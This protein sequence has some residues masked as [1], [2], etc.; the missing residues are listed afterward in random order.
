MQGVFEGNDNVLH[1]GLVTLPCSFYNTKV[2]FIPNKS[3]GEIEIIPRDK[4]KAVIAAK[5]TLEYFNLDKIYGGYLII[6]SNI[7]L[8]LGLGSSTSDVVATINAVANAFDIPINEEEVAKLAVKSETASDSIMFDRSVLF[9]QREAFIIEDF[10]KKIPPLEIVGFNTDNTGEGVDTL[11]FPP[12]KYTEEDIDAFKIL[13][14][15]IRRAIRMQDPSLIGKVASASSHINQKY[16]PK[17]KFNDIE[18]IASKT[19][20]LGIQVSHS[21]TIMGIMYDYK[22]K[23]ITRDEKTKAAKALLN[24]IGFEK[25]WKFN[26]KCLEVI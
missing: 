5:N 13:R 7:P 22:E 24:E 10:S 14:V 2:I 19:G 12:V 17:Y 4:T 26:T 9:A 16:L 1:R 23:K 11:S 21:G 18:K 6:N 25:I 20:A 8:R 15:A 3:I